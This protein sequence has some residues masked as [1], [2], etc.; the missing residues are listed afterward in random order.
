MGNPELNPVV[1]Q[2]QRHNLTWSMAFFIL[3][4]PQFAS[5]SSR[6]GE[7]PLGHRSNFPLG[8]PGA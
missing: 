2:R 6:Q 7:Q 1:G 8:D 3:Y 5:Y 4:F